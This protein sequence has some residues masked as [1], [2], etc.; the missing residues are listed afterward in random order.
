[1]DKALK[2]ANEILGSNFEDW[3]TLSASSREN[4]TEDF[5]REFADKVNW[6]YISLYQ[7][8]SEDFIREFANRV[9]W[10]AVSANQRLSEDFIREFKDKVD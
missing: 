2:R 6:Y 5:I 4:L 7:H 10:N 3:N 9:N 1:M 8:L